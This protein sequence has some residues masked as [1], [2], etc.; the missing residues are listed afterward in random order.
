MA[1]IGDGQIARTLLLMLALKKNKWKASYTG[2]EQTLVASTNT[3][4]ATPYFEAQKS[5]KASS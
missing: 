5:P 1:L 2:G 3:P 4:A